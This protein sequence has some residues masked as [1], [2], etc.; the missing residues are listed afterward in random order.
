MKLV[1]YDDG[2]VGYVD[3]D[4]HRPARRADDARVVRARR[5]GRD[6]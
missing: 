2:K 6:G 1:T 3:G 4:E 5:R